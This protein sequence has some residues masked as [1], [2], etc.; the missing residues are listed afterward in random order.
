MCV[1]LLVLLMWR[2][3]NINSINVVIILIFNG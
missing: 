1:I 3:I 2:N